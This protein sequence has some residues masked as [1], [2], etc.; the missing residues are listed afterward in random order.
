LEIKFTP[1]FESNSPWTSVVHNKIRELESRGIR[2]GRPRK[3]NARSCLALSLAWYRY[4]GS[5]FILQGW[6]GLTGTPLN[7]WLHFGRLII[8]KILCNDES[9]VKFPDVERIAIYKEIIRRRHPSLK[10]VYCVGDGLRMNIQ[11]PKDIKVQSMFYN[12]WTH[13][14]NITNLFLFSPDGLIIACVINAPGSIHDSTLCSWGKIY[15][16]LEDN[17]Y[18]TYSHGIILAA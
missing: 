11:V 15:D 10:T 3:I 14:H 2:R 18:L 4:K 7:K 13:S 16:I 6:F 17:Y 12:G 5:E 1:L 9:R 8:M